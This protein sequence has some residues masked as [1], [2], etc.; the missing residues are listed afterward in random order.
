M[1]QWVREHT[2]ARGGLA[3]D[4]SLTAELFE[5]FGRS[6]Q[7]IARLADRDVEDELVDAEFPHRI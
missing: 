5:H 4:W 1:N 7:P 6:G 3:V 2:Q